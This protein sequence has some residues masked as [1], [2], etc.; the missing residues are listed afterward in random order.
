M[1]SRSTAV[2]DIPRSK[3]LK[4]HFV[5][6]PSATDNSE[7]L[8]VRG[9]DSWQ[10]G[11]P[12]CGHE[13]QSDRAKLRPPRAAQQLW[14]VRGEENTDGI[15]WVWIET[16]G[17]SVGTFAVRDLVLTISGQ[18]QWIALAWSCNGVSPWAC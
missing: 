5:G 8:D 1:H 6:R 15:V 4:T 14:L 18:L 3:T 7:I 11:R 13:T 2:E 9:Q 10:K 17:G 16:D 12:C